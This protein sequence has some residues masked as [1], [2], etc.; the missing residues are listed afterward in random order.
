MRLADL[1]TSSQSLDWSHEESVE[2]PQPQPWITVSTM[3][4]ARSDPG[5]PPWDGRLPWDVSP[6]RLMVIPPVPTIPPAPLLDTPPRPWPAS[7]PVAR[8]PVP[9]QAIIRT[10]MA[11]IPDPRL[12]NFIGTLQVSDA[13][14]YTFQRQGGCDCRTPCR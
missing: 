11:R 4:A 12:I 1:T 5:L 8:I 13:A 9:P 14:S 2:K 10:A 7:R 6:L 3:A